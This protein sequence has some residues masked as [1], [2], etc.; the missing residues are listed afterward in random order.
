MTLTMD[1]CQDVHSFFYT[2]LT[3]L[4]GYEGVLE[5]TKLFSK[6]ELHYNNHWCPVAVN[7]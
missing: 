6:R 7:I 2:K 5:W 1:R 4:Y 3:L